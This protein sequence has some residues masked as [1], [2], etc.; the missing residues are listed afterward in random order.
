MSMPDSKT[1]AEIIEQFARHVSSGKAEFYRDAGLDFILGERE[2]VYMHDAQTGQK[3]IN[4][5]CNGGVFNLGHRNPRIIAALKNALEKTDI[6]NHHLMSDYRAE[7]ARRLAAISPG[8]LNRVVFGSSGG[9]IVDVA[10]KLSRAHTKRL[11]II[12]ANGGYHGHTGL[13]LA[14]GDE[15]YRKPFGP[16]PPGFVQ[17]PFGDVEALRS[18]MDE[19]TAAVLLETIPA[20]LGILIPPE[21]YFAEVRALCDEFGVVLIADEIQT[22][23]G[24]CGAFWGLD[25]YKVIPDIIVAAKGL[26]GGVYP[27]TAMIYHDDMNPFWHENPFIHISSFGGAETGCAVALEVLDML[28]EPDFLP[29][30]RQMAELFSAG[31]AELKAKHPNSLV[32]TRQR[33]LMMGLKMANEMCGLMMSVIGF[34]FGLF[35]VYANNDTSVSQLLPPLIISEDEVQQVL[36][37]LDGMLTALES[38]LGL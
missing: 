30:V 4:C 10:I 38:R 35:T 26:S 5:H 23:L 29:H 12:S 18:E 1:K 32:E 34:Q 2:G 13:A 11:K 37:A 24:R 9:E 21:D 36:G 25:T 31:F 19:T 8:E 15:K 7:L 20:T 3:L 17:I 27:I 28:E 14:T 33:G 16:P 6:G 22:G